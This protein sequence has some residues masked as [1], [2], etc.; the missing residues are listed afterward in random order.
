MG[1]RL[2]AT[3]TEDALAQIADP[4]NGYYEHHR[5]GAEAALRQIAEGAAALS[6]VA[7]L[8]ERNE[9]LAKLC[10]WALLQ[11]DGHAADL[12]ALRESVTDQLAALAPSPELP[13]EPG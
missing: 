10:G 9:A 4:A 6:E 13:E 2:T 8:R 5:R 7:R 11:I 1:D 3:S 12:M